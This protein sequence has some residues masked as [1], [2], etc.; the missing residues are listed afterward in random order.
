MEK[1]DIPPRAYH[2]SVANGDKILIFG[3]MNTSVLND[4]H[5]YN[6]ATNEWS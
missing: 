1:V 2:N 6:T 5:I 3:G 4:S